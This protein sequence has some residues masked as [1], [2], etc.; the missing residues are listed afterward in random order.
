MHLYNP[1]KEKILKKSTSEAALRLMCYFLLFSSYK[2]QIQQFFIKELDS[3]DKRSQLATVIILQYLYDN[4][5]QNEDEPHFSQLFISH[6]VNITNTATPTVLACTACE[7]AIHLFEYALEHNND[8]PT[9][10]IVQVDIP[11]DTLE[12]L[13]KYM[14]TLLNNLE[15][16]SICSSITLQLLTKV[17]SGKRTNLCWKQK[18]SRNYID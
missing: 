10:K 13:Y 15:T 9:S 4:Y 3:T 12:S 2:T 8:T 14:D 18:L 11:E 1:L 5:L 7:A 6:L 17:R 16:V